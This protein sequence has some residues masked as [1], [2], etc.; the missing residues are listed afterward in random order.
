MKHIVTD[1]S[2][3]PTRTKGIQ[4][5]VEIFAGALANA[6]FDIVI[7]HLCMHVVDDEGERGNKDFLE[8]IVLRFC[9]GYVGVI[10]EWMIE[11]CDSKLDFV[12]KTNE[13]SYYSKRILLYIC[14]IRIYII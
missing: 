8:F 14:Y 10:C 12:I 3:E 4:I 6:E 7:G 5:H 11:I 1:K 13:I 2:L 9:E